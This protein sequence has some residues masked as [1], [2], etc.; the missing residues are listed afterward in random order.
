M[1]R[2]FALVVALLTLLAVPVAAQ[3]GDPHSFGR[4][5]K[6]RGGFLGNGGILLLADC[7]GTPESAHCVQLL[8]AP[9]STSFNV[10]TLPG[11]HLF[12]KMLDPLQ[13]ESVTEAVR[14]Y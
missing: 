8:P 7:S 1:T 5:M 4:T 3:V 13:S 10:T 6:W 14:D 9:A 12:D 11:D 2:M